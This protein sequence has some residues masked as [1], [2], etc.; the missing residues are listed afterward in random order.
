MLPKSISENCCYHKCFFLE[1]FLSGIVISCFVSVF[2]WWL[3]FCYMVQNVQV[4]KAWLS[5]VLTWLWYP[6]GLHLDRLRFSGSLQLPTDVPGLCQM[7]NQLL[8]ALAWP[9]RVPSVPCLARIPAPRPSIV[10]K[11][12]HIMSEMIGTERLGPYAVLQTTITLAIAIIPRA[13]LFPCLSSWSAA[14]N[15]NNLVFSSSIRHWTTD[16]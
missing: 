15:T 1:H 9:C 11:E 6:N 2:I 4:L 13:I 12:N 10:L 16:S 8:H 14:S 3:S 5:V 7:I